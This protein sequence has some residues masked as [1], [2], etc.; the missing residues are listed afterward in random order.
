MKKP[1]A[2]EWWM[3]KSTATLRISPMM[4][5]EDGNWAS[6][7]NCDETPLKSFIVDGSI[8]EP[9]QLMIAVDNKD[10]DM[11]IFYGEYRKR[12]KTIEQQAKRIADLE[13]C[14]ME[15]NP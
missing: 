1:N 11:A 10:I 15:F 4:M 3:C 8:L 7:L 13:K 14:L 12:G 5:L 9:L 2:G 6:L